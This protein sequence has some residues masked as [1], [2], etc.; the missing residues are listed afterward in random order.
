MRKK[1]RKSI[2]QTW[3]WALLLCEILKKGRETDMETLKGILLVLMQCRKIVLLPRVNY[4]C[5][6]KLG[7]DGL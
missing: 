7:F 6:C 5:G 4:V 2:N 1:Q 3:C